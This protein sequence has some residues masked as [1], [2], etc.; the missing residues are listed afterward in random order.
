MTSLMVRLI[1]ALTIS[2]TL[3]IPA[4][5]NEMEIQNG[6]T[7]AYP[8]STTTLDDMNRAPTEAQEVPSFVD[9]Q[10]QGYKNVDVANPSGELELLKMNK[11]NVVLDS[12]SEPG[13]SGDSSAY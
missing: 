5:A 4:F 12:V 10:L 2:A 9:G 8:S 13:E 1:P 3:S 6:E 7:T 11:A